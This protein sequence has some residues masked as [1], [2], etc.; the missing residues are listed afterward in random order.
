MEEEDPPSPQIKPGQE[1]VLIADD[2]EGVRQSM[3]TMLIGYGYTG[4]EAKLDFLSK[5]ILPWS[6]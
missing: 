2:N 4:I 3:K 1:T 6:C 5:P